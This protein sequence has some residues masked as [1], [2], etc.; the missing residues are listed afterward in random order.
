MI[1]ALSIGYRH[2]LAAAL[3]D[4][5]A[6]G[7]ITFVA[8]GL[9]RSSQSRAATGKWVWPGRSGPWIYGL[10]SGAFFLGVFIWLAASHSL[11]V[12]IGATVPFV[13]VAG[14]A[15]YLGARLRQ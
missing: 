13:L 9:I 3:R 7:I 12:V 8:F 11:T 4:G 5:I 2:G 14:F 1:F 10:A 6:A 15:F